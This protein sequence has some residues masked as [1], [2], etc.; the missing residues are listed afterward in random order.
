MNSIKEANQRNSL[1]R[2]G[3]NK[4]ETGNQYE[5]SKKQNLSL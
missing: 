1:I 4:M 2:A 5:K 3:I